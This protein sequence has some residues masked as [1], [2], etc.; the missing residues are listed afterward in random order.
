LLEKNGIELESSTFT[1]GDFHEYSEAMNNL[2][3]EEALKLINDMVSACDMKLTE[4]KPWKMGNKEEIASV[5]IPIAKR[6][7]LI[8]RLL[9]P[10]MPVA[11]EKLAACF[12]EEQVKKIEPLF[13][14]LEKEIKV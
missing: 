1:T 13:P 5:L 3:F 9:M 8:G 7:W 6:I 12:S 2:A 11:A 10:F 4:T 14:R